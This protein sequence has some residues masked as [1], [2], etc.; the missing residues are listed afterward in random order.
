M[1]PVAFAEARPFT[2]GG[3][4]RLLWVNPDP[5]SAPTFD[6]VVILRKATPT[7]TVIADPNATVVYR[8]PG[9]VAGEFRS[10]FLP[11]D[12]AGADLYRMTLDTQAVGWN[13]TIYYGLFAT[14]ANESDVSA[15]VVLSALLPQVSTVEEPDIIGLL[16]PF[17]AAY[18]EQQIA[19]GGLL[20]PAHVTQIQ[21]FDGPP[22]MDT[23]V[24]P[25]VSLHLDEDRP[26]GFAL[27]DEIGHQDETGDEVVARRGFLSNV[28]IAVVGVTDNPEIRRSLYRA[29]KACLIAARQLLEQHGLINVEVSGRYAEDFVNYDAPLY[30]AELILRG[31]VVS[32]V[33]VP[34][35]EQAIGHID[36]AIGVLTPQEV[37]P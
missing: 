28:T 8:G 16:L 18:L 11:G 2:F 14:N 33:S 37:E 36:I 30:S 20:V 24:F 10:V 1:N 9:I 15:P 22:L 21:V 13:S 12:V 4:V 5:L 3:A 26:G 25:V 31:S 7:F 34:P 17:I 23:A 19:V 6:H 29:L 35:Q 32:S 27:G